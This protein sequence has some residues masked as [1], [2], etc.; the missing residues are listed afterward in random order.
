[1]SLMK[2]VSDR[3]DSSHPESHDQSTT[4]S[5]SQP[6]APR[7][8]RGKQADLYGMMENVQR[9]MMVETDGVLNIKDERLMK[10][11]I[12]EQLT[13]VLTEE[14][15]ML[16]R[17]QKQEFLQQ[18]IHE[19]LGFGP[20][21]PL[22][23]DQSIT[24]IMVIGPE[25]VYVERRGRIAKTDVI[26]RDNDHLTRIIDKILAP[27][28]RRVDE[29]SPMVDARLPDGSRIN[30]VVPPI[31]LDGAVLTV[32]KFSVVPLSVNDLIE[33]GTA[34]EQVFEFLA[35]SVLAG[36]NIIVAGGSS[37]G[38][39]TL[40]NVLSGFVPANERIV[41]IENA[42]EL[43]LRQPHV[44]R[45]ESRPANMEGAGEISVRDLMINSLRMRPDRIVVGEVR[46]GEAID[47]LQAMNTGHE[48]SMGTLH[49]NSPQDSLSRLETMVLGAGMNLPVRAIRDQMASA[50][51]LIVHM[52]RSREGTRR[53][54]NISEVMGLEGDMISLSELFRYES[55]PGSGV[56]EL[57]ATGLIPRFIDRIND[58]GIRLGAHVFQPPNWS[59]NTGKVK[60]VQSSESKPAPRTEAEPTY[61]APPA[62]RTPPPAP[63][64]PAPPPPSVEYANMDDLLTSGEIYTMETEQDRP[65]HR[66]ANDYSGALNAQG[67]LP[68]EEWPSL[69]S[70]EEPPANTDSQ[71][72]KRGGLLGRYGSSQGTGDDHTTT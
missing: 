60:T 34:T 2:R 43:Q 20:L 11:T 23:A 46:S 54:L 53:I 56:G 35:A 52:G 6:A 27:L 15:I 33:F 64:A 25:R 61:E 38:K 65:M 12:E 49:A 16:N 22:L 48:G 8:P 40:L 37:S 10:Q 71:Q 18:M 68:E 28:G 55:T 50:I 4:S 17:A 31:A 9:R 70:F 69:D 19:I 57:V 5:A 32:R 66:P 30:A 24:D 72:I 59:A 47:L 26:F 44:V 13:C 1:M 3:G 39:T 45:L 58:A 36:M 51:N 42:A 67:A 41:T 21:E 62:P 29:S 7:V 14:G 63:V